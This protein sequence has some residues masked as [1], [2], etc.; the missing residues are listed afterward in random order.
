MAKPDLG[1]IE[2]RRA[3]GAELAGIAR[4]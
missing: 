4:P 3:Y 1:T 2:G